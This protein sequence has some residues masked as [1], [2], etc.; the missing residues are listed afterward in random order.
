[1]QNNSFINENLIIN[2]LKADFYGFDSKNEPK[3]YKCAI[4]EI[5]HTK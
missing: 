4:G 2:C 1:M 5:I 3:P